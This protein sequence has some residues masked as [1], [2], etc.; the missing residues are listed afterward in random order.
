[1]QGTCCLAWGV[2]FDIRRDRGPCCLCLLYFLTQVGVYMVYACV[3][4]HTHTHCLW[5]TQDVSPGVGTR[6]LEGPKNPDGLNLSIYVFVYVYKVHMCIYMLGGGIDLGLTPF[7]L[8]MFFLLKQSSKRYER[9]T[10]NSKLHRPSI[11]DTGLLLLSNK[12]NHY[13]RKERNPPIGKCCGS[14]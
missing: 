3:Y 4:A 13:Q 7:S 2:I 8:H 6:H 9:K 1:M 5:G 10:E 11:K 14:L 12:S